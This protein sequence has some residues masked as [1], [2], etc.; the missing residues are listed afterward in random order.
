MGS[1][2]LLFCP[3]LIHLSCHHETMYQKCHLFP[4]TSFPWFPDNRSSKFKCRL[5]GKSQPTRSKALWGS[6][7]LYF[8]LLGPTHHPLSPAFAHL[9]LDA[10]PFSSSAGSCHLCTVG[11]GPPQGS[12]IDCCHSSQGMEACSEEGPSGS[13]SHPCPSFGHSL[14][15]LRRTMSVSYKCSA[16][17]GPGRGGTHCI[18]LLLGGFKQQKCILSQFWRLEVH[19]QGVGSAMPL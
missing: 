11:C 8:P 3:L 5:L 10:L 18:S 16:A 7:T 17:L 2:Q 4:I 14:H 15:R 1:P 13:S 19:N 6:V 9:A 12:F